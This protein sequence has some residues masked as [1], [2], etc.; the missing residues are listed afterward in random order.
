MKLNL[1]GHPGFLV[2]SRNPYF[3]EVVIYLQNGKKYLYGWLG[4]ISKDDVIAGIGV[5]FCIPISQIDDFIKNNVEKVKLQS[6]KH[7]KKI[8]VKGIELLN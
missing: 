6:F 2:D 8:E 4:N 5:E 1:F 7:K 3:I